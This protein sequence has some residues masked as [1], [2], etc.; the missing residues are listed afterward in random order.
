MDSVVEIYITI[1]NTV[2]RSAPRHNSSV[3]VIQFAWRRKAVPAGHRYKEQRFWTTTSH[4]ERSRLL[5]LIAVRQ[6]P[7]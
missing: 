6:V 3:S 2:G 5:V 7:L 1:P 4:Q